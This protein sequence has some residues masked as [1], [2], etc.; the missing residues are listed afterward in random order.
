MLKSV[1]VLNS[2]WRESDFR[3]NLLAQTR[4]LGLTPTVFYPIFDGENV[5]SSIAFSLADAQ[6]LLVQG[7]KKEL[8]FGII[9]KFESICADFVIV[10]GEILPLLDEEIARNLAA[11]VLASPANAYKSNLIDFTH[12]NGADEITNAVCECATPLKFE[13]S[14]LAKAR[15]LNRTV[16]LPESDDERILQAAKILLESGAVRIILLGDPE[17]IAKNASK[18]ELDLNNSNLKIIDPANNEYAGDFTTTLYELRKHKG[19]SEDEAAKLMK[20]RTYFGTMLVYKGFAHAM[21]SGAGTTTAQTIRPALQFVKTKPGISTVS[22]AFIMC[23]KDRIQIF[24][25]CAICPNPTAD[26]LAGIALATAQTARN[27]GLEPRVAVLSYSTGESGKGA[28]VDFV[29]EVVKK[30]RAL[31]SNLNIDGPMQFDAATDP[32]TA[33]KKAPNSEVAG[34]ANVFIFPN[35]NCGN[36]CYKAV[37]RSANALAIGPILQGLNKPVNDLS[38]GCTVADVVNTV[39]ISAL[40]GGE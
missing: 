1:F 23:L 25:D 7:K 37:Q 24:A 30:A 11:P 14:L 35:L 28:D 9:S 17:K 26:E 18:F 29:R 21:V 40:Q 16:V 22:G 6:N 19:M 33:A 31:D 4:T 32:A 8:L 39:L 5:N 20:D 10:V 36:I 12:V 2:D 3:E 15:K 13:M 27:F 38:R 34:K